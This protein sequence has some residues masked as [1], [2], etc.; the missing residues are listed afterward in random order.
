MLDVTFLAHSGFLVDD[1]KRAMCLII[2]RIQTIL[3]GN[4]QSV[5]VNCGFY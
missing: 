1:G 3:F 5:A 4:W 2:I